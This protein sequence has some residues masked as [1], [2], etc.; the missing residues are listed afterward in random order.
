M[1]A[2]QLQE[3]S[4]HLPGVMGLEQVLSPVMT[5]IIIME[6]DVVL[7]AQSKQVR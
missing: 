1:E 4:V 7:H 3:I 2:H 6:T 5:K